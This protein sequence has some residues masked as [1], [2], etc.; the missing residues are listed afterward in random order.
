[1]AISRGLRQFQRRLQSI[2]LGFEHGGAQKSQRV[3]DTPFVSGLIVLRTIGAGDQAGIAHLAQQPVQGAWPKQHGPAD[4]AIDPI[5]NLDAYA[6]T[7]AQRC[8]DGKRGGPG[9][10]VAIDLRT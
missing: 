4:R 2:G 9:G 7:I 6:R 10:H 1:V 5:E 3:M 8:Q